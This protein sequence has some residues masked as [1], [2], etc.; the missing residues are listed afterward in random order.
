MNAA[1]TFTA[2]TQTTCPCCGKGVKVTK[3]GVLANHGYK[4]GRNYSW[5]GS[6]CPAS[7]AA[8]TTEALSNLRTALQKRLVVVNADIAAGIRVFANRS[9]AEQLAAQ[10][11]ELI[12]QIA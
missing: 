10:I 11:A 2:G 1:A 7:S 9:N 12:A 6:Q 4:A 3:A 8:S 5:T